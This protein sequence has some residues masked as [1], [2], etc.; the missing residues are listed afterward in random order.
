M[1]ETSLTQLMHVLNTP[2]DQHFA[3]ILLLLYNMFR[4]FIRPSWGR[5]QKYMKEN[6]AIEEAINLI[7]YNKYYSH[8]RNNKNIKCSIQFATKILSAVKKKL[9]WFL[10]NY[11]L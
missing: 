9:K 4:M 7:K 5:R 2:W 11:D 1:L 6:C 3:F 8:R 10:Y